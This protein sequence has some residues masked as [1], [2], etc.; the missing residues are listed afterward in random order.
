VDDGLVRPDALLFDLDGTLVDTV[1]LRIRAWMDAFAEAGIPA[2]RSLLAPLMGSDGRWLAG[3]VAQ[4]AGRELSTDESEALDR[5]SGERFSEL[6]RAPRPLPGVVELLRALDAL[7]IPWSIATSS[8][9]EQ[10]A[11]SVQALGLDQRPRITDASHVLRAKPA[12]D[13]LLAGAAQ[14]GT[15]PAHCW[16]VG[17]STWDMEAARAAR[18]AAIGLPTGVIDGDALRAA[19]ATIVVANAQAVHRVLADLDVVP[20]PDDEPG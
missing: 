2:E 20:A 1:E 18:M 16:Y 6:N 17:D 11:A 14:M 3:H 4:A 9:P 13:L 7:G 8:R 19:G 15:D 10:V 5:R 12:P